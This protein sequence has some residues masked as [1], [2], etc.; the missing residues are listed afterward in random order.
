MDGASLNTQNFFE[1]HQ[2]HFL[3]SEL[4]FEII[5]RCICCRLTRCQASPRRRSVLIQNL[6]AAPISLGRAG[7]DVIA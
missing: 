5:F 7:V 4:F 2:E 1:V 3:H 6:N